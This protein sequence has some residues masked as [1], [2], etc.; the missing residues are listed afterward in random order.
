MVRAQLFH[1][2]R[3]KGCKKQ[4]G[5]L[6]YCAQWGAKPEVLIMILFEW[7]SELV[8]GERTRSAERSTQ[9]PLGMKARVRRALTDST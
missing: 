6:Q 9:V 8:G 5:L 1:K 7:G 3:G 4:D 2:G